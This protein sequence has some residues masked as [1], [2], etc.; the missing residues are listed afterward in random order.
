MEMILMSVMIL[1]RVQY[2]Y[3]LISK[4]DLQSFLNIIL[5]L[6]T[7]FLFENSILPIPKH[8]SDNLLIPTLIPLITDTVATAVM[9]QMMAV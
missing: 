6:V 3:A 9:H 1:T 4:A 7:I 2:N 5:T 8:I